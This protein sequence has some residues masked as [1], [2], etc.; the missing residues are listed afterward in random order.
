[1]DAPILKSAIPAQLVN[2]NGALEP[3]DLKN[4]IQADNL[5]ELKFKA[6]HKKAHELPKGL[7][8]T[9]DGLITGIPA[10]GTHGTYEIIVTAQSA[11]GNLTI[12]FVLNIQ[13]DITTNPL[14]YADKVKSQIWEA[15]EKELALP[16]LMQI[17]DRPIS[18]LDV[19]YLL[20]RWATLTVW[21]AFNLDPP[22]EKQL[23]N[24]KDVSPHYYVYD[25]GSCL[26]ATPKN[27]FSDDHT[28]RDSL[29]T[30]KAM[31]REVFDRGWTVQLAGFEKM[32]QAVWIEVG[33]LNNAFNKKIEIVGYDPSFK[34]IR[35]LNEF[36]K[37][38][39][40]QRAV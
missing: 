5:Q 39:P 32:A 14:E 24:L 10:S 21:D 11:A 6:K 3:L 1:M 7:I 37:Y 26:V 27:I 8:C 16:N 31:A 29:D 2:E 15:L 4:F 25:R 33:Q 38:S 17:Y 9:P 35:L 34:E 40:K 18:A 30:A 20:E 36:V 13:P 22:G 19:Y 23:L 28:L 12:E